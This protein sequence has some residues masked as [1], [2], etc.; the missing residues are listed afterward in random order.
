MKTNFF[1]KLILGI[2]IIYAPLQSMA[3]GTEGHRIAGLIA[4]SYLTPKARE[5]IKAILGDESIAS[6]SNWADFIKSDPNYSYLSS[7]HYIDFDKAYSLAELK[8]FLEKDNATDAY[9]KL[10]FMIGEMKKKET[11]KENRLL[12]LRMIIHIVEDLH[13]PMH[14]GHTADQGGNKI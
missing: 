10:S 1:K 6:A 13:Q 7:W 2:A 8:E 12:F 4:S 11:S 9:T 14:T 5:A 3:W